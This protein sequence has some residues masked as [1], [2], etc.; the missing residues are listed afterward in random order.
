MVTIY[1]FIGVWGFGSFV[2]ILKLL[3][4]IVMRIKFS[5]DEF[6]FSKKIKNY[7]SSNKKIFVGSNNES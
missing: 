7:F 2:S 3:Q 4:K 1:V 5:F 6:E